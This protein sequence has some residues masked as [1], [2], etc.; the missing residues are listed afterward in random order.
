MTLRTSSLATLVLAVAARTPTSAMNSPLARFLRNPSEAMRHLGHLLAHLASA[1]L[2]HVVPPLVGVVLLVVALTGLTR[3]LRAGRSAGDAAYLEIL[4]PPAV[5]RAGAAAF[6][7][8]AHGLL[9]SGSRLLAA[10]PQVAFE[11]HIAEE[12]VRFRLVVPRAELSHLARAVAAAWPGATAV[13]VEA[14]DVVIA[15]SSCAGRELRLRRAPWLPIATEHD[16]DTLRAVLGA[17][18][19]LGAGEHAIVQVLCRPASRRVT[20]KAQRGVL[21][22]QGITAPGPVLGV[23]GPVVHCVLDAVT[24]LITPGPPSSRRTP[25]PSAS[26]AAFPA[27]QLKGAR[28]KLARPC[29]EAVVRVA[30]ASADADRWSTRLQASR[31][32]ALTAAFSAYSGDNALVARG[33]RRPGVAISRRQLRRGDLYSLLELAALAHLPIDR[34]VPGVARSGAR[35]VAPPPATPREGKV[36][37]HAESG[38]LRPV[39]LAPRDA[40]QHMHLIGATGSG[41]STLMVNLVC[42]DVAAHRGAVVIDPKGDLVTDILD[43]LP[44]DA[45]DRVVVIDAEDHAPP[46]LN[47]LAGADTHLVVDQVTGVMSR[48]FSSAWGPRT[49]DV[50]RAALL[51]LCSHRGASLT[52]VPRLLTDPLYRAPLVAAVTDPVLRSFWRQYD[53]MSEGA[54]AAVIAP[55]TNKLRAFLLRPFVRAVV[56]SGTSS[57]SLEEVLDDGLLLCRVPKGILGDES[58]RLMG[59]LLVAQVWQEAAARARAGRVRSLSS[60]YLDECQNFL[61]LPGSLADMLAEARGYGLG[62]VLAHQTLSQLGEQLG[63]AISANARTKVIFNCSP[64]DARRLERHVAPELS[65]HDLSHLGAFQAGCRL[66]VDGEENSAFTL[67]T[68]VAPPVERGRAKLVR[69]C[70]R[71]QFGRSEM[72]RRAA[73]LAHEGSAGGESAGSEEP[74]SRRSWGGRS[75]ADPPDATSDGFNLPGLSRS[76]DAGGDQ[77]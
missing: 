25:R 31:V 27:S 62:L 48:L 70:S 6:W 54:R 7:S 39:A 50:C 30:V 18:A 2:L 3:R 45:A 76:S 33:L 37:G 41:K 63:D 46:A 42:Q 1:A 13:A 17:A 21:N 68:E 69:R 11:T 10:S 51:T 38:M 26:S 59:S 15:G 73:A 49:D 24:G 4:P 64:E 66:V 5:D 23:L 20:A 28:D 35:T 53:A 40:T 74:R 12:R 22:I 67:R 16:L 47:V 56:G 32:R 71:E 65:A 77:R 72:D 8:N 61:G 29:F 52:Q 34:D 55:L 60:L 75:P 19:E 57:F 43:R 58:V 44:V 36:L 14:K 9:S